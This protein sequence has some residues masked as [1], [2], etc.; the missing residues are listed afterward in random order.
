MQ[1]IAV[2]RHEWSVLD[3]I[4]SEFRVRNN[5]QNRSVTPLWSEDVPSVWRGALRNTQGTETNRRTGGV[6][7]ECV[8]KPSTNRQIGLGPSHLGT[9]LMRSS[10]SVFTIDQPAAAKSGT[11]EERATMVSDW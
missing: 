9:L 7:V 1:E 5:S 4:P 11:L 10:G 2:V 3:K 8:F 6:V